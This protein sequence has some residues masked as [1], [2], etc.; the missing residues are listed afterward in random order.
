MRGLNI[1]QLTY[2][3]SCAS[4]P[5]STRDR[6]STGETLEKR[7]RVRACERGIL[8][9]FLRKQYSLPLTLTLSHHSSSCCCCCSSLIRTIDSNAGTRFNFAV[10]VSSRF[11][12]LDALSVRRRASGFGSR[13]GKFP[14]PPSASGDRLM[15]WVTPCFLCPAHVC[16]SG[17][18]AVLAFTIERWVRKECT[19][20]LDEISRCAPEARGESAIAVPLLRQQP[21]RQRER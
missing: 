1:V 3:Q 16:A 21:Q 15:R 8:S 12:G 6:D 4:F 13:D 7:V 10:P 9:L 5:A 19:L 17:F 18:K 11:P 14:S 20:F 2:T